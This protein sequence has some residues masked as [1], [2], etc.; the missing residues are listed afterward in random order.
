MQKVIMFSHEIVPESQIWSTTGAYEPPGWRKLEVLWQKTRRVKFRS[1]ANVNMELVSKPKFQFCL[2]PQWQ[3]LCSCCV[4]FIIC[5]NT[6]HCTPHSD[7][8]EELSADL[9]YKC[10]QNQKDY[11]VCLLQSILA[12]R[13]LKYILNTGTIK[14]IRTSF[15][16]NGF[17]QNG[18][19]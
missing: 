8:M 1:A 3:P 19:L 15:A 12:I 17:L 16:N 9:G 13:A 5:T 18:T 6:G 10:K 14:Y 11:F 2:S 4:L 7:K